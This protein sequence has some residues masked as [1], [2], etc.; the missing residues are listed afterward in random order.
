MIDLNDNLNKF[1]LVVIL[2]TIGCIIYNYFLYENFA[3]RGGSRPSSRSGSRTGRVNVRRAP[4]T[5]TR[6]RPVPTS[7]GARYGKRTYHNGGGSYHDRGNHYYRNWYWYDYVSPWSW[8]SYWYYP[9]YPVYIDDDY[10]YEDDYEDLY[11]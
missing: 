7:S 1:L 2:I 3:V 10:Y 5:S 8:W 6:S 9:S 4:S 11:Y